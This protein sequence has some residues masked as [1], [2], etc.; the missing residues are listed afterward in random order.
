MSNQNK[1][2]IRQLFMD[3]SAFE[4]LFQVMDQLH[5]AAS[6]GI[7]PDVTDLDPAEVI[8]WLR[9]LVY[10]ANETIRE[11]ESPTPDDSMDAYL[12]GLESVVT[13]G[14]MNA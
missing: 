3:A 10:T 7:L 4:G 8:G 1:T 2:Q 5:D 11:I 14:G 9:D 13:H 12:G 6:A